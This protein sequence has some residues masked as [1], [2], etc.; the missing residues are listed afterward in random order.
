MTTQRCKGLNVHIYP[1]SFCHET[2]IQRITSSLAQRGIFDAIWAI[3]VSSDS[4]SPLEVLTPGVLLHRVGVSTN[5]STLLHKLLS[6]AIFYLAVLRL[7][8]RQRV[9]CVNAHSLSVL[10]LAGIIKLTKG[11]ALVYDTHEL[12]TE[13]HGSHGIR[14]IFGKLTEWLFIKFVDRVFCVGDLISEWY[15][16]NY[17]IPAPCTILNSPNF[18]MPARGGYL[19]GLYRLSDDIRI[20]VYVGLFA[21]DRGISELLECFERQR[22]DR[23]VIVFIGYGEF[24][25]RIKSSG[26]Y[27]HTVFC[28]PPVE[29]AEL[30]SILGSADFGVCIVI[31]SCLSYDYCMPNKL[32]QYL[33][34]GI[35]VIVSPCRSLSS[36]VM[37]NHVGVVA[38]GWSSDCLASALKKAH[39]A[40]YHSLSA[41]AREL[42]LTLSWSAQED[43]LIAEYRRLG[44]GP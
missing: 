31:P 34:S 43:T 26:V 12:E 16:A 35:P 39:E 37:R 44:F 21:A 19:R 20:F 23:S 29:E 15:E 5:R 25:D 22:A 18:S 24:E 36:F 11:C 40:D 28:H 38:T 7:L 27:G 4:L 9:V 42:G 6:F 30:G 2:R 13:S 33:G 41:G 10:P 17:G 1:S 32:F 3:G 14:K 8:G